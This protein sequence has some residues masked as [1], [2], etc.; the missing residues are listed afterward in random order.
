MQREEFLYYMH[1]PQGSGT[2]NL[3]WED[4]GFL[5]VRIP[6]LP[7]DIALLHL[8]LLD[9]CTSVCLLNRW[10]EYEVKVHLANGAR[11]VT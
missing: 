7:A 2:T 6:A 4:A 1:I 5:V 3:N 10:P 9:M 11:Q 8:S